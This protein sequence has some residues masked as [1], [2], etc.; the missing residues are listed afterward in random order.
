MISLTHT[1][2][3]AVLA[4]A[5]IGAHGRNWV[6]T[7]KVH[8]CTGVPKPY[9]RKILN[10]LGR[11]GLIE[12]KR[13]YQGGV[14]LARPPEEIT[15]MDI[16]EA[17]EPSEPG[18]KNCLLGL[19]GCSDANPCPMRHFWRK[20]R[21]RIEDEL[22]RVTLADAAKYV[23]NSHGILTACDS[24]PSDKRIKKTSNSTRPRKSASVSRKRL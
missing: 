10:A 5:C 15:L 24:S 4:L 21:L 12:T 3:Y 22:L 2:G 19:V 6:R 16:V 17:V 23:K 7:D 14:V 8:A 18:S 13:G 1:T 20:E 9:L 11:A